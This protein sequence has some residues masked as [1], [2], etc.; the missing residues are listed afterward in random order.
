MGKFQLVS[1]LS[2]GS[3]TSYYMAKVDIRHVY[4]AIPIHPSNYRATGLKWKFMHNH[5]FTYFVGAILLT[6]GFPLGVGGPQV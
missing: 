6:L 3:Y 5:H 4:R 2:Q 1:A